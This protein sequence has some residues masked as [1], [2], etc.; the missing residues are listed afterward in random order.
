MSINFNFYD[1]LDFSDIDLTPPDKVVEEIASE[2]AKATK[3]LVCIKVAEY[4]GH[5]FSYTQ[6]FSGIAKMLGDTTKEHDIQKDLGRVGAEC[7]KYEV[8][9]Y[10]PAHENYKFRVFFLQYGIA[11]Y[12]V[13][14]VLEQGVAKSIRS[15]EYILSR[16]NRIGLEGLVEKILNSYAVLAV[17][18]ELIRV[19]QIHRERMVELDDEI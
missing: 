14:L 15:S 18:Q 5:V 2:F 17:T 9:L 6:S 11:S 4:K 3:G 10:A 19:N 7:H 12:P 8:Y 1:K 16:D 13:K